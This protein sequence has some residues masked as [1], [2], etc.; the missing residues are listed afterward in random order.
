MII[1]N[2]P[3]NR[4]RKVKSSEC[5]WPSDGVP[6]ADMYEKDTY[7]YYLTHKAYKPKQTSFDDDSSMTP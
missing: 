2:L 6:S 4:K 3:K 1:K 7:D 5:I